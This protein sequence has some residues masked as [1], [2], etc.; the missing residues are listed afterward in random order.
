MFQSY[1]IQSF[2]AGWSQ[3]AAITRPRVSP[4]NILKLAEPHVLIVSNFKRV[5]FGV[6]RAG[7]DDDEE[8]MEFARLRRGRKR[9]I[10]EESEN[11]SYYDEGNAE[12]E[13]DE[14]SEIYDDDE[15]LEWERSDD[16]VEDYEL[17]G[18]YLVPNPL[19]DSIDPD[20]AAERFPEIASDPRFWFDMLL[21][22][23]FLD[24]VSYAGPRNPFPIFEF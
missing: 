17:L 23:T 13:V 4:D 11:K 12:E 19:L 14:Y 1:S 21:F 18:D 9:N 24:F 3:N 22:I 8:E 15:E 7:K 5:S 6:F 16:L 20:G 2:R 10:I